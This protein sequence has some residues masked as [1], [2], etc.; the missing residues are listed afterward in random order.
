MLNENYALLPYIKVD[1]ENV[2]IFDDKVYEEEV[3][4]SDTVL[5]INLPEPLFDYAL[6]NE[7][8]AEYVNNESS[9]RDHNYHF[10]FG[11][12]ANA[13]DVYWTNFI[14]NRMK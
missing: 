2:M 14:K 13:G 7:T 5:C 1:G 11:E 10:P 8:S 4:E 9:L 3:T 12:D 6:E